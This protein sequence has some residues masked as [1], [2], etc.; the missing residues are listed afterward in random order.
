MKSLFILLQRVLPQHLLSRMVGRLARIRAGWFKDPAIRLFV[1]IFDVDMDEA[2]YRHARDYADFN[3]F[4][5]RALKPNARPVTGTVCSPA[6]G[7]IS[8]VGRLEGE[9]LLQAKGIDYSLEKLLAANHVS[10]YRGGSYFTIY[11]APRDY[12]RVHMP[13][14]GE[15]GHWAYVPGKLFSVNE[16][17]TAR[18]PDLFARNERLIC[19]FNTELGPMALIMVGAMIVAGIQPVWREA[20]LPPRVTAT[21]QFDPPRKFDQGEEFGRFKMGST[22]I[23]LFRDRLDWRASPGQRV[24]FGTPVVH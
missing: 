13:V 19:H 6:D 15:L 23:L 11:L 5:T 21:D 1:K 14:A 2:E 8:A 20:P 7:T 22:V 16:T 4:F 10:Q 18:L 24:Q 3:T 9:R 17:T 12:H